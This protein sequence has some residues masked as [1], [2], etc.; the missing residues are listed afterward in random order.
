MSFRVENAIH[1]RFVSATS[2]LG[3]NSSQALRD[4]LVEK[5]EEL[6]ELAT[7]AERLKLKRKRKPIKKLWEEL[8]LDNN[9]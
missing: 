9:V 6:E 3:I 5:V 7:V 4:A 1:E 2:K 8:G